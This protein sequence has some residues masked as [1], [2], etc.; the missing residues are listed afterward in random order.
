MDA[1]CKKSGGIRAEIRE[2]FAV[3]SFKLKLKTKTFIVRSEVEFGGSLITVEKVKNQWLSGVF[4]N[5]FIF[6]E[7]EPNSCPR[8]AFD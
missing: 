6:T 5:A 4:R 7:M 3:C 8:D 2:V 1:S